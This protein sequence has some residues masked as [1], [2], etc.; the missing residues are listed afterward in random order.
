MR[1]PDPA[2]R[3]GSVYML[4]GSA[5]IFGKMKAM[6]AMDGTATVAATDHLVYDP[7][8]G[9]GGGAE[10]AAFFENARSLNP[11]FEDELS[12]EIAASEEQL[13]LNIGGMS[14]R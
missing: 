2:D 7:E 10:R 8:N 14:F 12:E 5:T 4:E 1:R 13:L 3:S 6:N 11:A 9:V